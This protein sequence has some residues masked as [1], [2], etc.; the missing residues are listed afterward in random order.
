MV[1]GEAIRA[2]HRRRGSSRRVVWKTVG[3]IGG[4]W[5]LIAPDPRNRP[6]AKP[7]LYNLRN[8]PWE[9][10]DLSATQPG[11]VKQLSKQLDKWWLP[12][13]GGLAD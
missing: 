7:E 8:D 10:N 11:K 1:F 12:A 9:K 5:K 6:N 3:S 13:K 4:W 2:Q